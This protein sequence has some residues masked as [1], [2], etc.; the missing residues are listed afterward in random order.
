MKKFVFPLQSLYDLKKIEEK[1][2]KKEMKAIEA[3]LAELHFELETLNND[4][5]DTKLS[6]NKEVE[7]IVNTD[8]L[9]QYSN[10]FSNLSELTSLQHIKIAAQE[11]KKE[12]CIKAQIETLKEIKSL[13][14]PIYNLILYQGG[15]KNQNK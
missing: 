6:Y 4:F 14:K 12:E 3:K 1:Q 15:L 10:Y 9:N 13:Q 5:A 11:M 7:G 2:Q 8:K